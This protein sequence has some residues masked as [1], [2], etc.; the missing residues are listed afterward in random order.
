MAQEVMGRDLPVPCR[1]VVIDYL[2][3]VTIPAAM[4][5]TIKCPPECTPMNIWEELTYFGLCS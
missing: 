3:L 1:D 4:F 2:L 5:G